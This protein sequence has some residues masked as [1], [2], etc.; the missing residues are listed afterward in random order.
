MFMIELFNKVVVLE[1]LIKI[2]C[3]ER[4]DW[5]VGEDYFLK[6]LFKFELYYFF[7]VR[8]VDGCYYILCFIID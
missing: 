3:I 7:I 6:L 2:K 5:F 8:G 1:L 4:G